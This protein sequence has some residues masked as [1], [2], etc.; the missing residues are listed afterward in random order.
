MNRTTRSSSILFLS[1]IALLSLSA[2]VHGPDSQAI[3]QDVQNKLDSQL[4]KGLLEIVSF[5][6]L[7]SSPLPREESGA[8]RRI[9]YFNAGL[10]FSEDYEFGGW[11]KLSPATLAYVLGAKEKGLF[12]IK[13]KNSAGDLV[14]VYGSNAYERDGSQWKQM[15]TVPMGK[16][17]TPVIGNTAPPTRSKQL[18][19]KLAG[20]VNIPPPGVSPQ[21][22]DV[23][24]EELDRAAENI[25]S[26][27]ERRRHV[28]TVASGPPG[29]QYFN[30][31]TTLVQDVQKRN[32][33]VRVRTVETSGSVENAKMLARGSA[34]YA[35]MQSDVANYAIA[36]RGP[37]AG[38]GP[39]TTL[40]CV[41]SLFPE[42]VHIVVK[43]S[44]PIQTISDL[45]GRRVD[46]GVK[47]S[48][49]RYDAQALL[50]TYGIKDRDL[51]R[52]TMDGPER[53]MSQLR[54]GNLDAFFIT[55]AAPLPD[56]QELAAISVIRFLPVEDHILQKLMTE[57]PG[58]V[59]M[60]MAA[61]TY[62]GQ[63]EAIQTVG[64]AA[65]LVTTN[66][67]PEAEVEKVLDL[68]FSKTP[69]ATSGSSES[70]KV[71]RQTALQNITIP[72]HPGASAFFGAADISKQRRSAP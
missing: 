40:R 54:K 11:E 29:S 65:L 30:Y 59:R 61:N 46:V 24:A 1:V 5:R 57:Y 63:R 4:K 67:A 34:D 26:R 12:G 7:G 13:S 38:S 22:D 71:S 52:L 51:A 33:K 21:E 44:S 72:M 9:V 53:A 36:G 23:I 43:A 56:L 70:A 37:F 69:V 3:R 39:V 31:A 27:I 6:R 28:Y 42:I 10:R 45:R 16:T 68:I 2:C 25:Q 60:T 20:M 66:Q 17:S 64:V 8:Q 47:D 49:T 35:L 50:T 32:G 19:D 18:I 41:T 15:E 55:T 62:P 58:I 14:Y 48:G